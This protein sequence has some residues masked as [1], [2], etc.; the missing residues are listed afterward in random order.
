[1]TDEDDLDTKDKRD[2]WRSLKDPE[3]VHNLEFIRTFEECLMKVNKRTRKEAQ[4]DIA[5][6]LKK[7][8]RLLK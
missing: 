2:V 1:M 8:E 5:D 3:Y 4:E 6:I 7:M